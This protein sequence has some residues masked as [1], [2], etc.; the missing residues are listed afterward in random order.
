MIA[1]ISPC[2]SNY[3][4]TLST[5]RYADRAR[6][7]KNQPVVNEDP[8]LAEL[9]SLRQQVKQLQAY[10]ESEQVAEL[11]RRVE[12][13]E[14]EKRRLASALENALEDNRKLSETITVQLQPN[15]QQL[16]VCLEI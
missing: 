6:K 9:M 7:I 1:C 15:S 14:E 2:K 3:E 8:M 4:E 16:E 12:C 11:R 5:L 13:A 10:S